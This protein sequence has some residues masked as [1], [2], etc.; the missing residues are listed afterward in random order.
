MKATF[1]QYACSQ[2][3]CDRTELQ[4][5]I[6]DNPTRAIVLAEKYHKAKVGEAKRAEDNVN[7]AALFKDERCVVEL[8]A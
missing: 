2:F 3:K 4:S 1:E 5:F 7:F 8:E 6:K